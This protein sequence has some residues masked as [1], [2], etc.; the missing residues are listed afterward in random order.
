MYQN[1]KTGG[2][3]NTTEASITIIRRHF[4]IVAPI[5]VIVSREVKYSILHRRVELCI[6]CFSFLLQ[7]LIRFDKAIEIPVRMPV[8]LTREWIQQEAAHMDTD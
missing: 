2:P 6:F 5:P 4:E 3:L 7:P 1:R 8:L